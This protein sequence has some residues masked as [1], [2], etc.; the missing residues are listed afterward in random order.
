MPNFAIVTDSAAELLEELA[1]KWDVRIMPME[2]TMG[3]KSYLH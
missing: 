2:F 1:A 3:G